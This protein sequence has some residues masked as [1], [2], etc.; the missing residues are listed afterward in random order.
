MAEALGVAGSIIAIIQISEQIIKYSYGYFKTAKNAH[1][2][3]QSV[4]DAVSGL[5]SI[6]EQS[7]TIIKES[8]NDPCLH[9]LKSLTSSFDSCETEIR[10]LS[11][12]LGIEVH[13]DSEKVKVDFK[14]KAKWPFQ[15][16]EIVDILK[17]I[18]NHKETF[19]LAT[20]SDNLEVSRQ[21]IK[22]VMEISTT[23]QTMVLDQNVEGISQPSPSLAPRLSAE[24]Q[25][26]WLEVFKSVVS[27]SMK[28]TKLHV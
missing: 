12:S 4:V 5:K 3:I 25:G 14:Q 23:L 7:Q 19:I 10:K 22:I 27:R 15:K 9:N 28:S 11:K 2:E 21:G 13:I 26:S 6:L 20:T 17:T 8:P 16:K 18:A 24:S 1:N